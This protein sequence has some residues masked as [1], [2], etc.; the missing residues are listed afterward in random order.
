MKKDYLASGAMADTADLVV[1]GAYYGT[2]DKG[3]VMS[4]FL[5]GCQ[6]AKGRWRT[7]CKCGNGHTDAALAQIN[8]ELDVVKISKDRSKVPPWLDIN[9]ANLVP[10]FV[11]RDPKKAPVWEI[12]GAEFSKSTAHTADGISIRFPRVTKVRDD[13]SWGDATSL[14]ELKAL[15][16]ASKSSEATGEMD[17]E[18]DGG[19]GEGAVAAATR[20]LAAR[21]V[22]GSGGGPIKA[23]IPK[24]MRPVYDAE[25]DDEEEEEEDVVEDEDE[26]E[27][28]GSDSEGAA[29]RGHGREPCR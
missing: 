15:V 24:R 9:A 13:K 25:D 4:V 27:D 29:P 8:R 26:D 1:L 3:G 20:T 16:A 11:V 6:D 10:D 2:G 17:P 7:V 5:M 14:D 18:E 12:T 28:I 23:T 19:D 21:K 22:G